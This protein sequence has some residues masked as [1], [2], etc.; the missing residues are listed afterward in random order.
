MKGNKTVIFLPLAVMAMLFVFG[1]ISMSGTGGFTNTDLEDNLELSM[2][3]E[4]PLQLSWQWGSFPE[5]GIAGHDYVEII[6]DSE[7][8]SA[9][10][11]LT[12]GDETL[13]ESSSWFETED[14]FAVAFPTYTDGEQIIGALGQVEFGGMDPDVVEE[15]RYHHTWADAELEEDSPDLETELSD[16][17]P[18]NSW[19]KQISAEEL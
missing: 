15:I 7:P 4:A 18:A 8:E 1:Y 19:T 5:D 13:Y 16:M 11:E 17:L 3:P 9:A 12:H 2:Q 10:L 6:S 14:G